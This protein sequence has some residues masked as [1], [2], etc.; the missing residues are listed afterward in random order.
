MNILALPLS[1]LYSLDNLILA[2]L[3]ILI[4]IPWADFSDNTSFEM[5][6]PGLREPSIFIPQPFIH[7][8]ISWEPQKL[9]A[10]TLY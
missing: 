2:P 1:F 3:N 4:I 5:S 8:K 9:L 6:F 7:F 10:V